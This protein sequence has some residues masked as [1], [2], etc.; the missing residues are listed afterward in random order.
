MMKGILIG[1][2][3][4]FMVVG[5]IMLYSLLTNH[6]RREYTLLIKGLVVLTSFLSVLYIGIAFWYGG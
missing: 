5:V 4:S 3:I 2:S 1:L 6:I